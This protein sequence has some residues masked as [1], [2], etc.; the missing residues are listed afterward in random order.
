M[1]ESLI[2][3]DNLL[4]KNVE[5]SA[6]YQRADSDLDGI[7][8]FAQGG[9]VS[10][11]SNN[12]D[13]LNDTLVFEITNPTSAKLN[14]NL[15]GWTNS[16]FSLPATIN[17]PPSALNPVLPP[18]G[19]NPVQAAFCPVNDFIYTVDLTGN[20]ITVI[21]CATNTVVVTI[22]VLMA[23]HAIVY[24][25]V[26]NQMYVAD[27]GTPTVIRI[28][29]VT[30]A[31]TGAAIAMSNIVAQ[32]GLVY[33]SVK[34]SVYATLPAIASVDEINCVTNL[35]VSTFIP[36]GV[37]LGEMAFNPALNRIYISD[38]VTNNI[39]VINCVTNLT[40][41][42]VPTVLI[43]A[44]SIAFCSANNTIYVCG[45]VSNNVVPINCI[46][47]VPGVAIPVLL[48][49]PNSIAYNFINNLL[50]VSKGATSDFVIIDPV[51]N[52]VI[53]GGALGGLIPEGVVYNGNDNSV[54]FTF[55]GSSNVQGFL[56]L[57]APSV[58]VALSG[59]YTLGDMYNDL[60]GK[61]L[62]LKGMKMI[63][64]LLAQFFNNITVNYYSIYGK[65][66]ATQFQPLNYVS[67]TNPN[68][69]IIDAADFE[70]EV[71]GN[72]DVLLD[73][74]PLSSLITSFTMNKGVDNT[75]PLF[76]DIT[77]DWGAG[78]DSTTNT[79]MTGNPVAD[80]VL[81]QEA[82]KILSESGY[83]S[84]VQYAFYPRETGN[85]VADIALLNA[86]GFGQDH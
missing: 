20:S 67:P 16:L 45:F 62:F 25:P 12:I 6:S 58:V 38:S 68:S 36:G 54:W 86:A 3:A 74:E 48:N 76:K 37:L 75:V 53:G 23:V 11:S 73:V 61:P 29:C 51:T 78:T 83:N 80:M 50:Y 28:D 34:N 63:V 18:T 69:L 40:I 82:N 77:E 8:N 27:S 21:N 13:K 60:Q 55:N 43:G 70:V 66:N 42:A 5:N 59:G 19:L 17:P 15:F 79:R 24:N 84:Q 49:N 56:P 85:P 1:T 44:D 81:L 2:V 33:N 4:E 9:D 64:Q 71:D 52:L 65:Q 22:P 10:F 31:I 47:N 46:T 41:V 35:V 39:F 7:G 30:N 57:V 14:V 32:S 72:T 26:N